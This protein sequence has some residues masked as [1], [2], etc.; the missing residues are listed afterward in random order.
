M[1]VKGKPGRNP[2]R[3]VLFSLPSKGRGGCFEGKPTEN[4]RFVFFSSLLTPVLV[5]GSGRLPGFTGWRD[6]LCFTSTAQPFQ[7]GS[8]VFCHSI[9]QEC[10]RAAAEEPRDDWIVEVSENRGGG[11]GGLGVSSCFFHLRK[12]FFPL[13]VLKGLSHWK[14]FHFFPRVLTKW[15]F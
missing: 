10:L 13:L 1:L 8:G 6:L 7:K 15:K 3:H 14:C 9:R 11:G 5:G 4:P 2:H 12:M